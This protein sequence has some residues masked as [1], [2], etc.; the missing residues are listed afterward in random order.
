[1][2]GRGQGKTAAGG[3]G[4][5]APQRGELVRRVR[6]AL[7]RLYDPVALGRHPLAARPGAGRAAPG[8][9]SAAPGAPADPGQALR[10]RLLEA[11]ARLR[12]VGGAGAAAA[13]AQRRH[14]LLEL[15]Y[16]EA[17]DPV[18]VQRHLGIEK[19]Q[20][21]REHARALDAVAALLAPPEKAVRPA[22]GI[23][24]P[25]SGGAAP[26]P[27]ASSPVSVG[28]AVDSAFRW[29]GIPRPPSAF[30]VRERRSPPCRSICATPACAT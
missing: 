22:P 11:I 29:P 6:D 26:R 13:G 21:Y 10:R 23:A 16:V 12:P 30:V 3:A 14:R 24:S 9:G 20:Y 17:L 28:P 25:R 15:R 18:T 4:G 1:M 2:T 27:M 19:S 5:G 7:A 8:A